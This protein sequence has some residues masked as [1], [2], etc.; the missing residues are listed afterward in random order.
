MRSWDS[1]RTCTLS[2]QLCHNKEEEI[3]QE[4]NMTT[5]IHKNSIVPCLWF[6]KNAEEAAT[7][8]AKTFPNS[9]VTKVYKSP[10]DYPNGKA[11]DVLTVEF[12]LL[13]QPFLGMNGGPGVP[14]TDAISYQVFTDTQEETDRYW[15][16]IVKGGGQEVA[17]GW[18]KDKFGLSWQIVPRP[19]MEGMND[20]DAAAAKRVMDA[21]MQMVK[22]DIAKI[23][24]ARQGRG[25]PK[26][27]RRG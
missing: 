11:G 27:A 12:T 13:G 19:L 16:A 24:A 7:F 4:E 1:G 14:F 20:P 9:R 21:M 5:P 26:A 23:E 2:G 6:D 25:S 3:E 8:Y 22:I 18:C 15:N 17:C 10:S